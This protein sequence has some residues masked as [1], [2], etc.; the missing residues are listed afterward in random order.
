ML[1]LIGT[2]TLNFFSDDA[3]D[4]ESVFLLAIKEVPIASEIYNK[5]YGVCF[6]DTCVGTFHV[7]H[8]Y[9]PIQSLMHT[10]FCSW[11]SLRMMVNLQCCA[12]SLLI[13]LQPISCLKGVAYYHTPATSS[14]YYSLQV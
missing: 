13:I 8:D 1:Y 6:L 3:S 5:E 9:S 10:E 4:G 2:R 7:M 12:C 11:G 14:T